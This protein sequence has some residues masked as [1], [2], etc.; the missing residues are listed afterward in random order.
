M[1]IIIDHDNNEIRFGSDDDMD[2]D[3]DNVYRYDVKDTGKTQ[4]MIINLVETIM[5]ELDRN[6][7]MLNISVM[8]QDE[9]E[10]FTVED[11]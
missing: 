4:Q 3:G 1:K 11:Y 6:K 8:K 7:K 10:L 2:K 9:G 5:S